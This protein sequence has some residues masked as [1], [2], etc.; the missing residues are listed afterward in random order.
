[1]DAVVRALRAANCDVLGTAELRR[2]V[3]AGSLRCWERRGCGAGIVA[4]IVEPDAAIAE[5]LAEA[6][7]I[8]VVGTGGHWSFFS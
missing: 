2:G 4:V 8:A 6:E 1:M 7:K 5:D 3:R